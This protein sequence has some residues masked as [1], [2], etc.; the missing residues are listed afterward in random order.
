MMEIERKRIQ[1]ALLLLYIYIFTQI[2]FLLLFEE[3]KLSPYDLNT[4]IIFRYL[5][6]ILVV[7]SRT[8]YKRT[9]FSSISQ[10]IISYH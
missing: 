1:F 8:K 2:I 4:F 6:Q 10:S 3:S 7:H 9:N 5:R